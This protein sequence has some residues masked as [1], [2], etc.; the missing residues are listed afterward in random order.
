MTY[1][2]VVDSPLGPVF[3]GG[4]EAGIHRLDFLRDGKDEAYFRA[5][6]EAETGASAERD[7]EAA[8]AAATQLREYFEGTRERFTLP[9]KPLGTD[10]QRQVWEALLDIPFGETSTY[11]ALAK[12]LGRPTASRA[13]GACVGRNPMSVVVPCH[14]VL[15]ANGALT[16][17]ASGLDRKRRLLAL[18]A[19][20]ALIPA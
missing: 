12:R 10:F 5:H 20:G 9:L 4:S 3:I 8:S 6:L 1:F 17:Y 15:G 7:P 2:D 14:R 18:E 16:G 19:H 13:V 11:G